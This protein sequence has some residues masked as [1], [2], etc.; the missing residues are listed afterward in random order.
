MRFV[1]IFT[2]YSGIYQGIEG[3]ALLLILRIMFGS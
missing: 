3:T 2:E 1:I